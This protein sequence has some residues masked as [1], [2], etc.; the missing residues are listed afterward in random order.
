MD[1]PQALA[2]D[3]AAAGFER[4]GL[5]VQLPSGY[6]LEWRILKPRAG[7][8]I[9]TDERQAMVWTC[10]E[11][12]NAAWMA[13]KLGGEVAEVWESTNERLVCWGDHIPANRRPE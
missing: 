11:Q 9:T 7:V 5:A 6:V 3:P 8:V 13:R 2:R 12:R 10:A 4:V 1:R